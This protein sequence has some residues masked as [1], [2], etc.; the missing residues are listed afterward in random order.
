MKMVTVL[1]PETSEDLPHLDVAVCQEK[2]FTE[3]QTMLNCALL[4]EITVYCCKYTT[5]RTVRASY[6]SNKNYIRN[7]INRMTF[8][9]RYRVFS[10]KQDLNT[11]VIFK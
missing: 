8:V 6:D 11:S 7:S 5:M 3:L 9:M 4:F 1:D 10:M 2:I